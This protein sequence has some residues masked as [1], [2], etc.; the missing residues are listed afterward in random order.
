MG[1][2]I[3]FFVVLLLQTLQRSI[4]R[5]CVIAEALPIILLC[6]KVACCPSEYMGE[7]GTFCHFFPKLALMHTLSTAGVSY[8]PGIFP[9]ARAFR[10]PLVFRLHLN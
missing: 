9:T 7:W 3:R 2:R 1:F 5:A 6:P 8:F 4:S 10:A